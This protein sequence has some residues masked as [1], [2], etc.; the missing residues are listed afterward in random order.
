METNLI[1]YRKRNGTIEYPNKNSNGT[2]TAVVIPFHV[3]DTS[4]MENKA[5]YNTEADQPPGINIRRLRK[6]QE[7][8]LRELGSRCIPELVHTTIRR[9]E[10]NDGWTRDTIMRLAK[11]LG[12]KNY[13]DLFLPPELFAYSYLDTEAKERVANM[14]QDSADAF[15]YRKRSIK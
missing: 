4:R 3:A 5:P 6:E 1:Y 8:S 10:N 2:F 11:A 7:L 12:I 13:T 15:Q 14:V 9:V